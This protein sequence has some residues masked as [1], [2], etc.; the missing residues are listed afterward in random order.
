LISSK[1]TEK[2]PEAGDSILLTAFPLERFLEGT[3]GVRFIIGSKSDAALLL[4]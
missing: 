2:K 1:G 4:I 3:P